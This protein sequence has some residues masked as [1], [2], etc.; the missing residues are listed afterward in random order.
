MVSGVTAL[1][2]QANPAL[3]WRDVRLVLA[4]SARE[5]D[6]SSTTWLPSALPGK[7]FSHRYGFGTVDAKAAIDLASTWP[8]V[9]GS[10]TLQSCGP[11]ART[12]NRPI[13]AATGS[14]P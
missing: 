8:T 1:V 12:P 5:N 3:T 6:A 7:R 11:Y 10:S 14:A 4:Q 2:L 13:P 9:G